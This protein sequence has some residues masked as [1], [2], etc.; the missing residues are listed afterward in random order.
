MDLRIF[1]IKWNIEDPI[2]K[3]IPVI[4]MT[5]LLKMADKVRAF[6]TGGT[7]YI[8]KLPPSRNFMRE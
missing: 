6:E 1:K 3:E 2:T 8:A 7:D 5:T 4:F